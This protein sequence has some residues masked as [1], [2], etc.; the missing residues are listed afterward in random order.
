MFSWQGSTK[1]AAEGCGHPRCTASVFG[2][3]FVKVLIV[4][5]PAH[6]DME[7]KVKC[8]S[9]VHQQRIEVRKYV[10]TASAMLGHHDVVIRLNKIT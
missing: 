9:I 10:F 4:H 3:Y 7:C 8:A 6:R 1:N 2:L 5:K